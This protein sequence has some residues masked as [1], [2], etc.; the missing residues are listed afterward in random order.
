[1]QQD[2][3]LGKLSGV[4]DVDAYKQIVD[5]LAKNGELIDGN[6]QVSKQTNIEDVESA[7]RKQNRKAAAPTKQ[8]N[9]STN[10]KQ[11]VNYL[12]LSDD[13]FIAKYA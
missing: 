6:Q 7:K 4:S 9:T 2:K 3:A 5:M 10:S 13:E 11:D 12:T 1:M 8:T